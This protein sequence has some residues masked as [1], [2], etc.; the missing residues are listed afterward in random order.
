MLTRLLRRETRFFEFFQRHAE[1]SVAAA[2]ELVAMLSQAGNISVRARKIHDLEHQADAITHEC[3]AA[4]HRSARLPLGRD[5]ILRLITRLDDVV[6]FIEASADRVDLYEIPT[7]MPVGRDLAQI[8]LKATDEIRL[9]V[10]EVRY[11]RGARKVLDRCIEINR[12]ENQA[13]VVLADAVARL[14][15]SEKDPI[16]II[17]WKE[18]YENLEMATDRCEDVANILEGFIAEHA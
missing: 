17:K 16:A 13:D 12:L 3:V 4:L 1:L 15:R 9:A 10:G 8:L 11:V 2:R 7:P 14:F 6:D 18:V 5:S